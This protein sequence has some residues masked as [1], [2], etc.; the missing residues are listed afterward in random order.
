[1]AIV[2]LTNVTK[3]FGGRR[4]RVVAVDSVTLSVADGELVVLLGP[5]G[6]GKTTTLR[7]VAGLER[8]SSGTIEIDGRIVNEVAPRERDVAMVF[9]DYALYP[10]L[11]VQANLAFGLK[12][13][14]TPK[15]EIQ[16]RVAEVVGFLGIEDLLD[17]KPHALSGGQQQRVAFGRAVV[18]RP[19]LCLFDEPLANL[20][21]RLRV[22]M[23]VELKRMQRE[24]GM[25]A[26]YVTHDQNE[27]MAL[28]DRLVVMRDGAVQQIGRPLEVFERPANR[29]VA[30]FLGAPPMNFLE[31]RLAG[32]NGRVAFE[33]GGGRI[34]V[35]DALQAL[36]SRCLG[37]PIVLGIR[38]ERVSIVGGPSL[39]NGDAR[40]DKDDA[41]IAV[42]VST[43]ESLG[44]HVNV[45][46]RTRCGQ[47]VVAKVAVSNAASSAVIDGGEAWAMFDVE[48]IALFEVG[49]SGANMGAGA[50]GV[51][52]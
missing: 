6:C 14:R 38:P 8:L 28:G 10:H 36:V 3:V 35:P 40:S 27:A 39:G 48:G 13:R 34:A 33:C 1:M 45:Y 47:E 19:G 24:L 16:R 20:D 25:T 31:G 22:Q 15:P 18:R 17:R 7:L 44:D 29:F 50:C 23:R 30:G 2:T 11:T 4:N 12:M 37:G 26:L 43:T 49:P 21:A 52:G 9:Q 42:R 5:S 46:S 32:A 51:E 41:A